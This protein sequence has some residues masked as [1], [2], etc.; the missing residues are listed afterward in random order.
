[1]DYKNQLMGQQ[2]PVIMVGEHVFGACLVLT[3]L[4]DGN[5]SYVTAGE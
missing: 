4:T 2:L 3:I 5:D 1:M